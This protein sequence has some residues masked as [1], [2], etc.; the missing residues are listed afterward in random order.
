MDRLTINI[1]PKIYI[2]TK[3]DTAKHI[4]RNI[5]HDNDHLDFEDIFHD[6]IYRCLIYLEDKEQPAIDLRS[7]FFKAFRINMIRN[8][9]YSYNKYRSGDDISNVLIP[10]NI[11]TDI[12]IDGFDMLNLVKV[13]YGDI[14]YNMLWDN[15][16][17]L[18]YKELDEKYNINSFYT[19]SKVKKFLKEYYKDDINYGKYLSI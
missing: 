10:L 18:T 17:G 14:I 4:C 12:H 2:E 13:T 6:T 8:Y 11:N 1:T 5:W 7:Y 16:R 15:L 19:L 9:G 3:Y